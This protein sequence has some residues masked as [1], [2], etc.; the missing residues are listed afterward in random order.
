[1]SYCKVEECRFNHSHTTSGH[2]CGSCGKF[3]HGILECKNKKK[4]LCLHTDHG[5]DILPK[6][7]RC[8][9]KNCTKYYN[10]TNDAHHCNLCNDRGHALSECKFEL[11]IEC[12]ICKTNNVVTKDHTNIKGIDVKCC[13]CL[14]NNVNVLFPTCKHINTCFECCKILDKNCIFKNYTEDIDILSKYIKNEEDDNWNNY[15]IFDK[16]KNDTKDID[17]KVYFRT[18]GGMGC[19]LYLR[20]LSKI[21]NFEIFFMHGDSWGQYGLETDERHFL[22]LFIEDYKF[23]DISNYSH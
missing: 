3:G 21:D 13:V 14:D 17:G 15:T 2:K 4:K 10:H 11:Q 6:N 9:I 12:P 8:T 1:M 19:Q 20:R 7:L 5:G 18:Y 23:I 22:K 16:I